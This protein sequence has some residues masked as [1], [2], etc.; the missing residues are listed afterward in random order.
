MG[1]QN[2]VQEVTTNV[3][4]NES[5]REMAGELKNIILV[6]S[7]DLDMIFKSFDADKTNTLDKDEFKKLIKVFRPKM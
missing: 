6:N 1:P 3:P 2:K 5:L 4:L 7:L